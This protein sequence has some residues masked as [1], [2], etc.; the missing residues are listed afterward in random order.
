MI[1]T[2]GERKGRKFEIREAFLNGVSLEA[3]CG[4]FKVNQNFVFSCL[5]P[6]DL[7]QLSKLILI[8]LL[9]TLVGMTAAE[10]AS[11]MGLEKSLVNSLLYDD[12]QNRFRRSLNE[13]PPRWFAGTNSVV[14]TGNNETISRSIESSEVDRKIKA[15]I[16]RS[17][18]LPA[19]RAC[20]FC[21]GVSEGLFCSQ[22][23]K[24]RAVDLWFKKQFLSPQGLT[25]DEFVR[26]Y[27]D[28]L[29]S[30]FE[31]S[32]INTIKK[33]CNHVT[34]GP[35][36]LL[37]FLEF[38]NY[39]VV[40]TT[41]CLTTAFKNQ[42]HAGKNVESSRRT[43]DLCIAVA[44]ITPKY[45]SEVV[46]VLVNE[47]K[48]SNSVEIV[49][50]TQIEKISNLKPTIQRY[51]KKL[52]DRRT[53][54]AKD[55]EGRYID[56]FT[57]DFLGIS[58]ELFEWIGLREPLKAID[59]ERYC[60]T[61]NR[62]IPPELSEE[63]QDLLVVVQTHTFL[64]TFR[65]LEGLILGIPNLLVEEGSQYRCRVIDLLKAD[66]R[67]SSSAEDK[68]L[69]PMLQALDGIVRGQT[70]SAV[71]HELGDSR[72]RVRQLLLPILAQVG[73]DGVLN[74]R[75][76]GQ[77]HRQ[78]RDVQSSQ[79]A[80]SLQANLSEFIR[81]HPGISFSE[82]DLEFP[83]EEL[84][85]RQAVKRHKALILENFPIPGDSGTRVREDIIQSLK[86]ASLLAFPVTGSAYDE[87][88][89]Q[90]LIR[91]LSRARVIQVFGTWITACELAQV[92]SGVPR[93]AEYV[94]TYGHSEMLKVVGQFLIDDDLRG[95]SGG[96]QTYSSWRAAQ[97]LGD[98]L[99]SD[100]TIRNQIDRSWT[101]VKEL[102]LVE[103]RSSWVESTNHKAENFYE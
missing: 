101:R 60:W 23:C 57:L 81:L 5:K 67:L 11:E 84:A 12:K 48:V 35:Q 65:I 47:G 72:E 22:V 86:E 56:E 21:A 74:L 32:F 52:N 58:D 46:N 30:D 59:L 50:L 24:K 55:F 96:V 13:M 20:S 93:K 25:S 42:S 99:P 43:N 92:E 97:E 3:I 38:H 98:I 4:D 69:L 103:L 51:L 16:L 91:G 14:A 64:P 15:I 31:V 63:F 41:E 49:S 8:K 68:R 39:D 80:S 45:R 70:L 34:H 87:L 62:A 94:R 61:A 29:T 82:L 7:T 10:I 27:F 28:N 100:G 26:H 90:G 2:S 36:N 6:K 17:I 102:A 37:S 66:K 1:S 18:R 88:L 53:Q 89:E 54:L 71:G 77:H 76:K 19:I 9:T 33:T 95:F 79:M 83:Q 40:L 44:N 85:L 78:V 75:L 73:V